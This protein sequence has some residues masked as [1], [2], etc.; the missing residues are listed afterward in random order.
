MKSKSAKD[1]LSLA[2]TKF[3]QKLFYHKNSCGSSFGPNL[4]LQ[5]EPWPMGFLLVSSK[6][7][8]TK[9]FFGPPT[10]GL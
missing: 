6:K 1:F 9:W 8:G 10:H 5:Y 7:W 3:N 2:P 4:G